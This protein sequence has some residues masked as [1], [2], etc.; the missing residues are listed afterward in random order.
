MSRIHLKSF[1]LPINIEGFIEKFWLNNTFYEK[2]L[3]EKLK[4]IGIEI[5]EWNEGGGNGVRRRQLR[6][7]HPA[8]ISFP[9]LPSHAEVRCLRRYS[10]AL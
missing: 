5:G 10:E 6:S 4:D 1:E 2:F 9:G 3:S 7:F 8:K